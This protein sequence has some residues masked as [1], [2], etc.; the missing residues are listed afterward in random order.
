[1]SKQTK[2]K[3]K[4]ALSELMRYAGNRKYLTYASWVLSAA[5]AVIALLPFVCIFRII[6]EIV[7]VAPDFSQAVNI[8]HNGVWAVIFALVSML[9]YFCALMCS[10][11]SAFRVA[12]NI[13]K[14]LM[15][16]ITK[17]PIFVR[18]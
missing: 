8:V 1:M 12:V 6:Q 17:L 4:S 3:E 11:L 7:A 13:R 18:P 2:N 9:L 15:E 10:H 16:H 5:S 14:T